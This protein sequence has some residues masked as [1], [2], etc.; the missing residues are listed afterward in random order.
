MS[1][2]WDLESVGEKEEDEVKEE[3]YKKE[4]EKEEEEENEEFDWEHSYDIDLWLHIRK[5]ANISQKLIS[6]CK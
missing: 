2:R 3:E 6:L 4:E 5:I 1:R